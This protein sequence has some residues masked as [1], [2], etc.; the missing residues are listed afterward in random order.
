MRAWV[1]GL[2][3][4][5]LAKRGR[6]LNRH[7]R[8]CRV[9]E[10]VEDPVIYSM[11]P[12]LRVDTTFLGSGAQFDAVTDHGRPFPIP[13]WMIKDVVE[14]CLPGLGVV[15]VEIFADEINETFHS[16]GPFSEV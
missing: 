9:P 1:G 6:R 4:R 2:V 12:G 15:V 11:L 3:V 8:C 14:V 7:G 16:L 13:V 5:V 10:L